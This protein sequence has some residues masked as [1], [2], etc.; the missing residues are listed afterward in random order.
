MECL[1]EQARTLILETGCNKSIKGFTLIE[2]LVVIIIIGITSTFLLIKIG[3]VDSV[4]NKK[5]SFKNLFNYL[6]EES[7]ITGNILGWYANNNTD[8]IFLLDYEL[9]QLKELKYDKSPWNKLISQTKTFK[10]FDGSLVNL[11]DTKIE[12]PL[13]IF[14]PSGENSGGILNIYNPNSILEITVNNNG[15]IKTKSIEY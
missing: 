15:T 12:K 2:I 5:N 7:I 10:S 14:Y 1:A 6:S 9:N 13:I 8:S 4:S 11:K 3:L